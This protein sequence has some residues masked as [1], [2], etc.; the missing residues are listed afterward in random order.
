MSS[1]GELFLGIIA[2]ATL[3]S[4]IVQIAVLIV[5]GRL[6]RRVELLTVQVEQE[7]KPLLGHINAIGRDASRAASLATSQMERV[8]RLFADAFGRLEQTL[9]GVQQLI[10]GPLREGAAV[11]TALRAVVG[12]FREVRGGRSRRRS[13]DEDALFI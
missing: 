4:S 3:A 9:G 7:I 6:A 5:A 1:W 11:L 8:D 2:I 13:E 10:N 12:A